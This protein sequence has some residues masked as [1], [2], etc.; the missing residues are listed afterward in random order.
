MRKLA[1]CYSMSCRARKFLVQVPLVRMGKSRP[2]QECVLTLISV[3]SS[4][5]PCWFTDDG[6]TSCVHCLPSSPGQGADDV[7]EARTEEALCC[8]RRRLQGPFPAPTLSSPPGP[9]AQSLM[10]SKAFCRQRALCADD[11]SRGGMGPG[12]QSLVP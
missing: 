1:L 3:L 5:E 4:Q 7:Q 10:E 2:R 6:S 12:E 11:V 8:G 9:L